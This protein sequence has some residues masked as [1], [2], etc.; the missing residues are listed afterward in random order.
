M[1][2]DSNDNRSAANPEGF[3][4]SVTEPDSRLPPPR[5]FTVETMRAWIA[6]DEADF[7]RLRSAPGDL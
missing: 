4:V 3:G 1:S 2:S 7:E 6:E 5:R